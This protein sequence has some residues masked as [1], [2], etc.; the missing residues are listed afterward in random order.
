MG[1][2]IVGFAGN[3]KWGRVE[4]SKL[5]IFVYRVNFCGKGTLEH[6]IVLEMAEK[7]EKIAR[8]E[9]KG[10]WHRYD[11][12][13][14]LLPDVNI[15]AGINGSGKSTILRLLHDAA[16]ISS[17]K[18][19]ISGC[20]ELDVW[21]DNGHHLSKGKNGWAGIT[22]FEP[23]A[24]SLNFISTF[25]QQLSSLRGPLNESI[26]AL[27]TLDLDID[28]LEKK[29]LNYQV[30]LFKRMQEIWAKRGAQNGGMDDEVNAYRERFLAMIDTLFCDSGKTIDRSKN[31][32][33]FKIGDQEILPS[34]LSAGEKQLL[35]ILMT[36]LVQDNRPS[37]LLMDEPEISLHIDWQKKLIGY[38]REL[39]PNCQVIIATH[40]PAIIMEGWHDHVFEVRDLITLD[41][42]A[43]LQ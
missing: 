3:V 31:E 24:F 15:L 2:K 29:Y 35:I 34:Q 42:N 19:D 11:L 43:V 5:L 17:V 14:D 10:L 30:D 38:I 4:S 27:T 33:S 28:R 16:R 40:S 39:N 12:A 41:R 9:I 37:I 20:D 6:G 1:L 22:A 13:W 36:V 21:F 25:D 7:A 8:L 23:P 32:V 26:G 18:H